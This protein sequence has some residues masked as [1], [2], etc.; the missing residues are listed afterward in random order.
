MNFD[1]AFEI[2]INV[3][4]GMSLDPKDRGNWTGDD[5]GKGT[6]KGTKYGVSGKQYPN[7]DIKNL[8]LARAKQ[9]YLQDYWM[10]AGCTVVPQGISF[11]LFD[12]A[13]NSGVGRAVR[14]LQ[15]AAEVD[16]DGQI[17]PKT[18]QALAAMPS[19]VL[20]ARFNAQRLLFMTNAPSWPAH[21]KGWARRIADNL[22]RSA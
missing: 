16:P 5:V 9:I 20:V 3:E 7:E 6:L 12:T 19:P 2:L 13:V 11:D 15:L 14:L 18:L 21:G 8:T 10:P 17:G 22:L 1:Q 4:K